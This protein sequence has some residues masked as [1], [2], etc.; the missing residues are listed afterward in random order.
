MSCRPQFAPAKRRAGRI[1]RFRAIAAEYWTDCVV[2]GHD[3]FPVRNKQWRRPQRLD[4]YVNSLPP[5]CRP[6]RPAPGRARRADPTAWMFSDP[7]RLDGSH[8]LREF[9]SVGDATVAWFIEEGL[10]PAHRVLDVGCGIGR[11]ALP[12]TKHLARGARRRH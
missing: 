11:M 2:G 10:A 9:I 4:I 6:T 7:D 12:L 1:S 3:S 8:D 5:H